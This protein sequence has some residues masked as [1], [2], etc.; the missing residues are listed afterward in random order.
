MSCS[1][2]E[3]V[4]PWMTDN[5]GDVHWESREDPTGKCV[6]MR[7]LF[8]VCICECVYFFD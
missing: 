5:E 8:S 4:C 1:F 3:G 7:T 6:C 2:D